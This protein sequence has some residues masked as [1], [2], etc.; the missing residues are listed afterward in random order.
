MPDTPSNPP[1]SSG[2][3]ATFFGALFLILGLHLPFFPIWLDWVGLTSFQIA[4][5]LAAPLFL[6]LVIAPGI[7]LYADRHNAHRMAILMLALVAIASALVLTGAR[8]FWPVF[9][10]AVLFTMAFSTIMPLIET[11]AVSGVKAHGHDYGRMRLWG[12]LSFI[13]VGFVG[14]WLVDWHGPS[15][16]VPMLALAVALT[17]LAGLRLPP[18]GTKLTATLQPETSAAQ[19]QRTEAAHQDTR[20]DAKRLMTSGLFFVFLLAVSAVQGAHG[21]F[22]TFGALHWKSQGISTTWIGALWAIGVLAEV[23]LFAY[24]RAC[25]AHVGAVMLIVIG[26]G[27]GVVRWFCMA[28]DPALWMLVPLQILH[29][30][31]YG[32]THLGAIYFMARAIPEHIAG[33]AQALYGALAAGVATGAM[34]L[35]SGPLYDAMQAY[36]Y[37]VMAGVAGVGLLAALVVKS[38]WS[39]DYLIADRSQTEPERAAEIGPKFPV[40]PN[41]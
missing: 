11:I 2:R 30:A 25:V 32:A 37:L 39:G 10:I 13:G 41:L 33:T 18:S 16:I 14:G 28:W 19:V 27:A 17:F 9:V 20:R 40:G 24:S 12:S 3:I 6:R 36:G 26:A 15:I 5:I 1:S 35:S 38:S 4:I 8:G 31:T 34:T 23:A 22:Y 29:G 21:L 7:A